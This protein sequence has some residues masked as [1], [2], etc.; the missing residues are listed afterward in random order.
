MQVLSRGFLL[1]LNK[2]IKSD[3]LSK[4][5]PSTHQS[6]FLFQYYDS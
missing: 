1:Y 2:R 4:L 6:F 5:F 3:Q